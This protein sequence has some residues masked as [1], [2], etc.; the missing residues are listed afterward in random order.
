MSL[1]NA[2]IF[3]SSDVIC[4]AVPPEVDTVDDASMSV[5]SSAVAKLPEVVRVPDATIGPPTSGANI[6]EVATPPIN[7]VPVPSPGS[8]S[9][10]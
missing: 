1:V 2:L 7:D 5:P 9:A 10:A 6:D 4:A 8:S 3:L